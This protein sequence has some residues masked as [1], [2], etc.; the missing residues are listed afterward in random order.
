M[1]VEKKPAK[2]K[3]SEEG[4][5]AREVPRDGRADGFRIAPAYVFS[6]SANN[7]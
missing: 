6:P 2:K 7:S 3:K 5:A 4:L 1:Q